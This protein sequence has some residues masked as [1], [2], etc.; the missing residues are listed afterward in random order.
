VIVNILQLEA[1]LEAYDVDDR[2]GADVEEGVIQE[3]SSQ[4]AQAGSHDRAPQPILT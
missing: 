2:F 1:R 3:S 4:T